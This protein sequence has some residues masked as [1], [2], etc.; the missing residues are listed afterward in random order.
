MRV[1]T[2]DGKD[3]GWYVGETEILLY[4]YE[5]SRKMAISFQDLFPLEIDQKYKM[6]TPQDIIQY[7]KENLQ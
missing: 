5:L 2:V 1:L 3:Y 7:I 4:D 6:V